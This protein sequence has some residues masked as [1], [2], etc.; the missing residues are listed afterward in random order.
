MYNYTILIIIGLIY[1]K[2]IRCTRDLCIQ[3]VKY[4]YTVY[5]RFVL[6]V[7]PTIELDG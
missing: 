5:T 2:N 1:T 3:R 4:A 7:Y 6:F